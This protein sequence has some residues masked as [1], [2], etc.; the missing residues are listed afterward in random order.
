MIVSVIWGHH[1]FRKRR[2]ATLFLILVSG[3]TLTLALLFRLG[4][5]I[6]GEFHSTYA[7]VQT[8]QPEISQAE[9]LVFYRFFHHSARYYADFKTTREPI[10]SPEELLQYAEKHPQKAY[11][12][13]TKKEGWKELAQVADAGLVEQSGDFYLVRIS[14]S[15][16]TWKLSDK[17]NANT[18][19]PSGSV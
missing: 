19:A 2:A 17:S 16:E 5:P 4:S 11:L 9:P 15:P 10:Q 3:I 18:S 13:L 8:A 12:L 14:T 6:I 1:E 7:L